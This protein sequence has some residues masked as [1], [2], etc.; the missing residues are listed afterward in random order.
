MSFGLQNGVQEHG[1]QQILVG[2]EMPCPFF[3][4]GT[5]KFDQ[6]FIKMIEEGGEE[7]WNPDKLM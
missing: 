2:K 5:I 1:W 4:Q 7:E 6:A 3:C